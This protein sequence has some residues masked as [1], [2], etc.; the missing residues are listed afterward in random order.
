MVYFIQQSG[1]DN[2]PPEVIKR[3]DLDD[4][5]IDFANRLLNED[6]KPKQ[7]SEI[8]ILPIP[9]TGDL[10]D[11]GNYRGISLSSIVA[12]VVN[13]MILNR[14]Q[15]QMDNNLRPNQ[16][17]FRPGR[18]TTSHILALRRLI[19]GV[20]SYNRKTIILYV[21]FQKAY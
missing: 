17:G 3:Y 9:K 21:D 4:I 13:K 10:S 1:P 8:N 5:I 11:T 18:S 7:W 14:I 15:S 16:N 12:K 6:V 20:K 19:E 2:V